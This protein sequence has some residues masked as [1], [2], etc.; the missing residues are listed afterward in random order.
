MPLDARIE[1]ERLRNLYKE[2]PRQSS[3]N[4]LLM[5]ETGTGK[6]YIAR[7]ARKP[8]HIDSFDPSGTLC[9]R[10]YILKGDIIVDTQYENEDPTK[11]TMFDAW[12]KNFEQR[13]KDKYFES[14]GTYMLD[15][16]TMFAEAIMN[17][18]L[19]SANLAGQAPRFTHDYVPQKVMIH[20][21][22]KRILA[23]PCDVIIT[24]HIEPIKD[25][26]LGSVEWRFMTTG[27][28]TVIIPLLFTE[29]WIAHTKQTAQGV[30]YQ[31]LT[32]RNGKYMASSSIAAGKLSTF[33]EPDIKKILTKCGFD[34]KDKPSL[35]GSK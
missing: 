19:K 17:K 9:L 4:L 13:E 21:C 30:E 23:L 6:T 35:F 12:C 32:Q 8:V 18:I 33:E 1:A 10:E 14:F 11:P 3:F 24:G 16:S 27:K 34:A 29:K 15:S 7:T 31:I 5:G 28:G 2:D 25:E 26:V 22:F 20:N